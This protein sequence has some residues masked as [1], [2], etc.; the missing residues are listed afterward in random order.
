MAASSNEDD[1]EDS[2]PDYKDNDNGDED[3]KFKFEED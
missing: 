2:S 3:D 1:R